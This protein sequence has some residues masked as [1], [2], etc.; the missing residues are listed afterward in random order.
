MGRIELPSMIFLISG[1]LTNLIQHY[2]VNIPQHCKTTKISTRRMSSTRKQR[3]SPRNMPDFHT[4]KISPWG[5]YSKLLPPAT[6]HFLIEIGSDVTLLGGGDVHGLRSVPFTRD[7]PVQ[8]WIIEK[9]VHHDPWQINCWIISRTTTPGGRRVT[10]EVIDG[11]AAVPKFGRPSGFWNA[12]DQTPV[13]GIINRVQ[14]DLMWF[15]SIGHHF[16][17]QIWDRNEFFCAGWVSWL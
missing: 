5:K 15:V 6:G 4:P 1:A 16:G 8:N 12:L 7:C 17:W 11:F 3:P 13:C 10:P 14:L 2:F 9:F